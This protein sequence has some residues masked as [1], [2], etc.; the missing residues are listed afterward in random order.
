MDRIDDWFEYSSSIISYDKILFH[1]G[2]MGSLGKFD[3]TYDDYGYP[4]YQTGQY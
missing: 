3:R 4:D 2:W 1:D